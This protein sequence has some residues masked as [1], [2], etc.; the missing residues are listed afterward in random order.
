MIY[1][2]LSEQELKKII[3]TKISINVKNIVKKEKLECKEICEA[4]ES[5]LLIIALFCLFLKES[6]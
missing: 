2:N 6:N 3:Q 4:Y 1:T 5:A